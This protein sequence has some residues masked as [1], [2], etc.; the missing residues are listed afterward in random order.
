MA[1][2]TIEDCLKKTKGSH[3]DLVLLASERAKQISN[4]KKSDIAKK[5][6]KTH[7]T[8]LR[9][10]EDDSVDLLVLKENLLTRMYNIKHNK[11]DQEEID[12]D[13]LLDM[14]GNE[15][16]PGELE[17]IKEEIPE[18]V[19]DIEYEDIEPEYK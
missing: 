1:R 13:I 7:V 3:F 15:F 10:I 12:D 19:E 14:Q 11:N 9:E 5:G 4:G 2:V 16:V 8:A 17:E 18:Q 6:V